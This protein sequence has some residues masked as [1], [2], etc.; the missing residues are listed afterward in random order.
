MAKEWY[1]VVYDDTFV[2]GVECLGRLTD[3]QMKKCLEAINNVARKNNVRVDILSRKDYE[4]IP[5]ETRAILRFNKASGAE[6]DKA[7]IAILHLCGFMAKELRGDEP[8]I[9]E[10]LKQANDVTFDAHYRALARFNDPPDEDELE[11]ARRLRQDKPKKTYDKV[12]ALVG[13]RFPDGKYQAGDGENLR[14]ALNPS[15][16]K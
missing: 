13:E 8:S 16:K 7:E 2:D 6:T 4:K 12:A 9:S 1:A 3:S 10:I 14:K 5:L 15:K 11:Y